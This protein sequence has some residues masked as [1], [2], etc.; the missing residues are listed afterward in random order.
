V[1]VVA[2]GSKVTQAGK[3][4]AEKGGEAP[5]GPMEQRGRPKQPSGRE[6]RRRELAR[7]QLNDGNEAKRNWAAQKGGEGKG[8]EDYGAGRLVRSLS[9]GSSPLLRREKKKERNDG[10]KF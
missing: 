4:P 2:T 1:V 5:H 6:G 9:G 8:E 7:R 10:A 3:G